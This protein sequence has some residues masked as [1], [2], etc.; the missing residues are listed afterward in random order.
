M[1]RFGIILTA[2]FIYTGLFA[3]GEMDIIRL[4]SSD[5][6]GAA[7][8]QSMG[9]AFGALGGDA[10]GIMINPAGLGVY[11]SSENGRI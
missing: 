5:L 11:R 6:R 2:L 7:R 4:S 9:G 1:K 3:Q 10:A 8:G